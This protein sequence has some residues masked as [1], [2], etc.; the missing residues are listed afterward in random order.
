MHNSGHSKAI[1]N[2][3]KTSGK[4][5][6][7]GFQVQL[8]EYGGGSTDKWTKTSDLLIIFRSECQGVSEV[9]HTWQVANKKLWQQ[10]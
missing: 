6:D 4:N 1:E 3:E 9:S 8:D 7:G 10:M 5:V 2:V